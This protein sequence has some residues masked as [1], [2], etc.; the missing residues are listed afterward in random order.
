MFWYAQ[1]RDRCGSEEG[2]GLSARQAGRLINPRVGVDKTKSTAARLLRVLVA[3]GFLEIA[4]PG[5]RIT[6][7]EA[8]HINW[9]YDEDDHARGWHATEYRVL[10]RLV[11]AEDEAGDFL[12]A[13]A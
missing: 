5:E 3:D 4:Q 8:G 10:A 9:K 11:V 13:V 7:N 12:E 6:Y 2:F 1:L